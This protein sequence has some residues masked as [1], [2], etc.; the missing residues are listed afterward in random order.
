MKTNLLKTVLL[1]NLAV[2]IGGATAV[3]EG[4]AT[5]QPVYGHYLK[6]QT[7]LAADSMKGVAE[8]AKAIAKAVREN[9]AQHWP[10][11]LAEESEALA[12]TAELGAAR[13]SFKAVSKSLIEFWAAHDNSDQYQRAYCP[14]A[15]AA[16]LQTGSEIRNPYFG[17]AMLHCGTPLPKARAESAGSSCPVNPN[18]SCPGGADMNCTGAANCCTTAKP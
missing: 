9:A 18:M 6:I 16:W 15:K 11:Q 3:A 13:E 17:K 10:S 5:A 1:L 12:R 7:A 2:L 4:A 14:M 8:N